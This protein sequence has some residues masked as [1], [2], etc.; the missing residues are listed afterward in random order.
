M[1]R[2][3]SNK[4]EKLTRRH[5][6]RTLPLATDFM[7][8]TRQKMQGPAM[9]LASSS[10]P[11]SYS[12]QPNQWS[13]VVEIQSICLSDLSLCIAH[14]ETVQSKY[15]LDCWFNMDQKPVTAAAEITAQYAN[16]CDARYVIQVTRNMLINDNM[17][18]VVMFYV[19]SRHSEILAAPDPN[20][21]PHWNPTML[22][23]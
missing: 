5:P 9:L 16:E 23:A 21:D 13:R 4:S 10:N 3:V 12:W 15:R 7:A 19:S 14:A 22:K 8:Q 20:P 17:C 1:F 2:I 18:K 11:N 6:A